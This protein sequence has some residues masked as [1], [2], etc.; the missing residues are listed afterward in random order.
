MNLEQYHYYFVGRTA[1]EPKAP[2]P[3]PL[4]MT[5]YAGQTGSEK[6]EGSNLHHLA[7]HHLHDFSYQLVLKITASNLPF[8][9]VIVAMLRAS[10]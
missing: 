6:V 9:S 3:A 10:G 4:V 7:R 2:C 5:L 8:N 1:S